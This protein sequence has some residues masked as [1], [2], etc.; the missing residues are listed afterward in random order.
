MKLLELTLPT[1]A[2]NLAVDDALLTAAEL[3]HLDDDVLRLWEMSSPVVVVG[4]SSRIDGEVNVAAAKFMNVPILRRASGG[5]AVVAG[6]GCLMYSVMLRYSGR[7]HLRLI[8]ECHRHVLSMV[9]TALSPLIRGIELR[10][11]SDLAINDRKFSGNSLRCKRDHLL[12]HG[13]ILYNFDV[14]LIGML[15]QQPP[16]EPDYRGSRP[17]DDFVTNLPLQPAI[18]RQRLI[19]AFDARQPL[20]WPIHS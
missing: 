2:E 7:E 12:Y 11:T 20:N 15:L 6:P 13:T 3:G 5:C 8:D 4:R 18:I 14:N 10:G 19:D 16:R 9:R 1:P 17:H